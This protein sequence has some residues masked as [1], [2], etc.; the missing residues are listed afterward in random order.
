MGVAKDNIS[1]L[2]HSDWENK[3]KKKWNLRGFDNKP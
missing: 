3:R 1:P 2:S